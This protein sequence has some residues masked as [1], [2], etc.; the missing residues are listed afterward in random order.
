MST[1]FFIEPDGIVNASTMEERKTT[2]ITTVARS[3]AQKLPF[4]FEAFALALL[5]G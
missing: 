3:D 2:A 1:V 4:G 5:R